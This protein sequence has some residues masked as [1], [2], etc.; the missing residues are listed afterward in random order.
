MKSFVAVIA[1]LL[2]ATSA[3]AEKPPVNASYFGSVAIEGT[4]P[5]AYF[6]DSRA[7][8]GKSDFIHKWQDAT[9]HFKNSENQDAFAAKP[10][11]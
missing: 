10:E 2:F 9:W 7:V 8:K 5:V 3:A 11:K 6:K 1:V 4:D